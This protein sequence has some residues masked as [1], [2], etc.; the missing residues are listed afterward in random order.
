MKDGQKEFG[1][2]I[3]TLVN[4]ILLTIVYL[5]GVGVTSIIARIIGKKFLDVSPDSQRLSYWEVKEASTDNI[6]EY[7]RQF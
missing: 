7:L 1:K 4:S 5:V 2:T 6:K 3:A